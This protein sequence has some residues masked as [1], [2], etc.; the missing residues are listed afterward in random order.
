ME[1]A[2]VWVIV[3]LVS[4]YSLFSYFS[5]KGWLVTSHVEMIWFSNTEIRLM[6]LMRFVKITTSV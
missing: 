2:V 4:T 6:V 1:L 5:A 3:G